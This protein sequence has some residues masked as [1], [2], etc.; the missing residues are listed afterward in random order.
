MV[1]DEL[2]EEPVSAIAAVMPPTISATVT[3][4]TSVTVRERGQRGWERDSVRVT[5][6]GSCGTCGSN[7]VSSVAR[8][9]RAT[10]H[11]PGNDAAASSPRIVSL[12][13]LLLRVR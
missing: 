4:A 8:R 10:R 3:A 1:V 12:A 5:V 6:S 7:D 13:E 11:L 2:D 9:E